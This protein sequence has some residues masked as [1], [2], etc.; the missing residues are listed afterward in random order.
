[1]RKR[2]KNMDIQIV[3]VAFHLFAG[4]FGGIFALIPPG[5]LANAR[6]T[7]DHP[8]AGWRWFYRFATFCVFDFLSF[9]FSPLLFQWLPSQMGGLPRCS[10][11]VPASLS[12]A[13]GPAAH[14]GA[15]AA[16]EVVRAISPQ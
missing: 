13:T 12:P 15:N 2:R 10:R 3:P 9:L 7:F 16:R 14:V 11:R 4:P 6:Q 8:A 5:K 1:M